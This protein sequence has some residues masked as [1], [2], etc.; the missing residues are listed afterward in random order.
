MMHTLVYY[1]VKQC[2]LARI[3]SL[4]RIVLNQW[5]PLRPRPR[6][7][8]RCR[9][10]SLPSRR[11]RRLSLSW[12]WGSCEQCGQACHSCSRF[13]QVCRHWAAQTRSLKDTHEQY[14]HAFC[15]C[16]RQ[17]HW[18]GSPLHN[19]W[20]LRSCGK[21]LAW[22]DAAWVQ[23][24]DEVGLRLHSLLQ[25]GPILRSARIHHSSIFWIRYKLLTVEALLFLFDAGGVG[26][27][28]IGT[29]SNEMAD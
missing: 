17:C 2:D 4:S 29:V 27:C 22:I 12:Q 9:R 23:R 20:C 21:S 5:Y 25:Y 10:H 8:S 19:D 24:L 26:C 13:W 14:G 15:N 3:Q 1:H 18:P 7:Q 6:L 11:R 16:S 28:R